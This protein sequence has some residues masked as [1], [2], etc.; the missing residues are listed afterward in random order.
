MEG[1][2]RVMVESR[3]YEKGGYSYVMM[4][5]GLGRGGVVMVECRG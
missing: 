2:A 3:A 4:G 1:R 5:Q